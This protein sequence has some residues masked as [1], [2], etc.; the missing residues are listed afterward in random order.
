METLKP[1]PLPTPKPAVSILMSLYD[2]VF[3][4]EIKQQIYESNVE[5]NDFRGKLDSVNANYTI[6]YRQGDKESGY[7]SYEFFNIE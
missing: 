2:G 5:S 7:V 3:P 6:N 1:T 4:D